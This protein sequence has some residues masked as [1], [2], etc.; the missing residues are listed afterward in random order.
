MGDVYSNGL[1]NIAAAH[2]S[3]PTHGLYSTRGI[4]HFETVTV[5]W[6]PYPQDEERPYSLQKTTDLEDPSLAFS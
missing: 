5:K 4:D 2:A 6:G 1:I 3:G